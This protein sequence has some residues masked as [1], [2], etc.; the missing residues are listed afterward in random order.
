MGQYTEM[1]PQ[2][3][4]FIDGF[5]DKKAGYAYDQHACLALASRQ[6][7]TNSNAH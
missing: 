5:D 4:K 6:L 2:I 7:H 1:A 3:Q